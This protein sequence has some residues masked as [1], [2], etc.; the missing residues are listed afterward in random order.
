MVWGSW[1]PSSF[2]PQVP[3]PLPEA[4]APER[5]LDHIM[6]SGLLGSGCRWLFGELRSMHGGQREVLPGWWCG[7]PPPGSPELGRL[8]CPCPEDSVG[9]RPWLVWAVVA[10]APTE[11]PHRPLGSA[12]PG[13]LGV[14]PVGGLWG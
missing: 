2:Y 14:M 13:H 4:A 5:Q 7:E 10:A 9:S 6:G 1:P 3:E 12:S 11:G 8:S